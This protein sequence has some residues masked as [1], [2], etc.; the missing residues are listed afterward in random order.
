MNA[1]ET[2]DTALLLAG[3]ITKRVYRIKKTV[4][5]QTMQYG[6]LICALANWHLLEE[7]YRAELRQATDENKNVVDIWKGKISHR[8]KL[9]AAP[10]N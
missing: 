7:T 3:Q 4:V 6:I 2:D 1:P 10:Y 5:P 8:S 9:E